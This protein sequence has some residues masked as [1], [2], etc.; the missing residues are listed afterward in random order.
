MFGYPYP[1]RPVDSTAERARI[2]DRSSVSVF[3]S[4][5]ISPQRLARSPA[6]SLGS[7]SVVVFLALFASQAGV[8]TLA[9]ILSDVASNQ[10]AAGA[11]EPE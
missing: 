2:T 3:P 9:P 7:P 11:G 8:L 6:P 1:W 5:V 4:V 10:I